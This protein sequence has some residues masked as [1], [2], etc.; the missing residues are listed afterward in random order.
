MFGWID[1][2]VSLYPYSPVQLHIYKSIKIPMTQPRSLLLTSTGLV[3]VVGVTAVTVLC[4]FL[5]KGSCCREF[6]PVLPSTRKAMTSVILIFLLPLLVILMF[7]HS[8]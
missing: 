8:V 6:C 3:S 5:P 4:C 2:S 1:T 7:H